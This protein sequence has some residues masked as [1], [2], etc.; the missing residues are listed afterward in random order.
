[1]NVIRITKWVGSDITDIW[2]RDDLFNEQA[3]ILNIIKK[4]FSV[5]DIDGMPCSFEITREKRT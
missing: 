4:N 5:D 1:M 3:W 2:E